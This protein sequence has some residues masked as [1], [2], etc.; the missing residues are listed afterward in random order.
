MI[1]YYCS[2]FDDNDAFGYGLGNLLKSE[3]TDTKSIVYVPGSYDDV[4]KSRDIYVPRYTEY[5]KKVGI[6]FDEVNLLSL[7]SKNAK[8]LV[9][10]ASLVMLMGGDPFDEIKLCRKLDIIDELKNYNGIMI[11]Y[12]AGSM[13]MSKYII[14]TPCSEEYPD[15]RI[16][17]G[18]NFDNLSIY[19]HNNTNLNEYPSKLIL[20]D[21]T[22]ERDDLI[23]VART[24]GQFYLLQDYLRDDGLT[25]VSIIKSNNG[26]IEYYKEQDGRIWVVNSDKIELLEI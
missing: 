9:R 19:P 16:E 18:L 25:D 13:I 14:I 20:E 3:L 8:E 6:E 26:T 7:D 2:G 15:F 17:E 5:F 4:S 21:E 24:Y 22:Y 10:N 1:R 12:S 11:G 23:K